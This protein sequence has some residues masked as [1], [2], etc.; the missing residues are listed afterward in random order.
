MRKALHPQPV[1]AGEGWVWG[2]KLPGMTGKKTFPKIIPEKNKTK[3]K[4]WRV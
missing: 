1:P 2:G 3:S 4:A